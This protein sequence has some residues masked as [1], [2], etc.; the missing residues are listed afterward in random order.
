MRQYC[1]IPSY[2][3]QSPGL[4]SLS[5][6]RRKLGGAVTDGLANCH[7]Q[8]LVRHIIVDALR[9]RGRSIV[10]S[11]DGEACEARG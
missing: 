2:P 5:S 4:Y 1:A 9:R 10:V 11:A 6:R 8:P 7:G 3:L